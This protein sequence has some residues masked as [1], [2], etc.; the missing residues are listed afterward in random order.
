MRTSIVLTALTLF[1]LGCASGSGGS[2]AALTAVPPQPASRDE[3]AEVVARLHHY[4]ELLLKMDGQALSAMFTDDGVLSHGG[5][6][7]AQTPA[8]IAAL[9]AS[10]E[11]K[12]RVEAT[13]ST[14]EHVEVTGDRATISGHFAQTARFLAEDRLLRASGTFITDWQR[15]PDGV[16]RL[17]RFETADAPAPAAPTSPP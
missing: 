5:Q 7:V 6:V 10:F 14:P 2:G 9:F 16:W 12:V 8:A 11:G 15:A 13:A 3:H 1:A 17:R 4:D